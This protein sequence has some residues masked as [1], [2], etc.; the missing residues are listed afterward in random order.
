MEI[1]AWASE[2]KPAD[3]GKNGIAKVAMQRRHSARLNSSAE[4]VAHYQVVTRAEFIEKTLNM[5]EIIAVVGVT[6][7]HESPSCRQDAAHQRVAVAF[8]RHGND[9]RTCA[10]SEVLR[11]I[12]GAVI[13][14]HN[15]SAGIVLAKTA[16]GF[17]HA[18]PDGLSLV[19]TRHDDR[20][21]DRLVRLPNRWIT[22]RKTV[23]SHA[24]SHLS[25]AGGSSNAST[26]KHVHDQ[27][28]QEE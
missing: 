16:K 25:P 13:G 8:L 9:P 2:E 27:Q 10:A 19:Q 7:Q 23:R 24:E 22:W 4:A 6:H 14:N 3:S 18:A 11:A 1:A 20:N 21:L 12:R 28:Y 15:L 5:G 26:K 17:L